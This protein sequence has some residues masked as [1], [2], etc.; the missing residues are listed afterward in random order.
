MA[1]LARKGIVPTVAPILVGENRAASVYYRAKA[2]LAEKL[3]IRFSGIELPDGMRE[4]ELLDVIDGLN[5]D[6][7]VD[8]ISVE[9]PLPSHISREKIARAI[10]PAKDIDGINPVSMGRLLVEGAGVANYR[11]LRQQR[12]VLSTGDAAGGDGASP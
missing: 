6:P 7:Q 11:Q 3:G 5:S 12:D 8:G 2:R 10:C 4:E 9:L 1:N